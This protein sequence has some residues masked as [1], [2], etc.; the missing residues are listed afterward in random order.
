MVVHWM[1]T[2]AALL[3]AA[4]AENGGILELVENTGVNHVVGQLFTEPVSGKSFK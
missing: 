3:L 2:F 1:L 4:T